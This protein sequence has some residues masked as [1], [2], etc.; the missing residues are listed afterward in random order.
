MELDLILKIVLK[1][2]PFFWL[3]RGT[4]FNTFWNQNWT[5]KSVQNGPKTYFSGIQYSI[6]P[7]SDFCNTS[8]SKTLLLQLMSLQK[9]MKI[10][11]G[12]AFSHL[13]KYNHKPER[14]QSPILMQI[15]PKFCFLHLTYLTHQKAT[16]ANH[17]TA[18]GMREAV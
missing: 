5:P 4:N 10:Q 12:G 17:R 15:G 11:S 1:L 14:I 7:N 16:S 9:I 18:G 6:V 8:L 2:G 3:P 13:Q